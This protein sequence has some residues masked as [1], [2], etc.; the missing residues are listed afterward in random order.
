MTTVPTRLSDRIAVSVERGLAKHGEEAMGM[1]YEVMPMAAQAQGQ[2]SPQ[3]AGMLVTVW[4]KSAPIGQLDTVSVAL[5]NAQGAT[6]VQLDDAC[7]QIVETLRAKRS[8]D[9][10]DLN[11]HAVEFPQG[12]PMGL[13]P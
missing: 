5:Q 9:L 10:A 7:R 1:L 12:P 8:G 4:A 6:E 3:V 2:P 13:V 11:G